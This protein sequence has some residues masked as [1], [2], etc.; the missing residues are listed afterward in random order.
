MIC[1]SAQPSAEQAYAVSPAGER[2]PA[3]IVPAGW[4]ESLWVVTLPPAAYAQ[5][6]VWQL[7]VEDGGRYAVDVMVPPIETPTALFGGDEILLTGFT[8]GEWVKVVLFASGDPDYAYAGEVDLLADDGGSVLLA[9]PEAELNY[10]SLVLGEA[11]PGYVSDFPVTTVQLGAP[12]TDGAVTE[13][14]TAAPAGGAVEAVYEADAFFA[15]LARDF[16]FQAEER[17]VEQGQG[18]PPGD[19]P[20]TGLPV[21]GAARMPLSTA[22]VLVAVVLVSTAGALTAMVRRR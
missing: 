21:T 5:P 3:L 17:P 14:R 10:A 18:G 16:F 1:T 12:A 9:R 13:A 7:V 15:E 20:P 19:K 4:R 22:A 6:G 2:V 8:P 11:S